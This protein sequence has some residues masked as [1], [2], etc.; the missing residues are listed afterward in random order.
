MVSL[1]PRPEALIALFSHCG[2]KKA[3]SHRPR[4][5]SHHYHLEEQRKDTTLSSGSLPGNSRSTLAIPE[6]LAMARLWRDKHSGFSYLE[7]G[8]SLGQPL[9]SR[10]QSCALWTILLCVQSY[11]TQDAPQFTQDAP[12]A[13]LDINSH[14]MVFFSL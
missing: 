6:T 14:D 2:G 13:S 5:L 9:V 10:L 3:G 11:L 1:R 8:D 12:Q 4:Q 7:S